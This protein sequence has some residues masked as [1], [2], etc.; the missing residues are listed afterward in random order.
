MS[1]HLK[2]IP[3]AAHLLG[4][5]IVS[6]DRNSGEVKLRFTA[7]KEFANRH[8]TVQGGMLA[9]MLDSA[10]GNAVMVRLPSH[11]TAVTTRL[12]T[13]F[14]RP[15]ALGPM[16]ATARLVRQDDRLAEVTAELID[17]EGQIVATARA[18]LRVRERKNQS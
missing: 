8:G 18:E 5:E 10:T 3:P 1:D 7:K 4:R 11:L 13:Q 6:A 12:D 17:V 15:A 9:A 14:L 2:E 16:T